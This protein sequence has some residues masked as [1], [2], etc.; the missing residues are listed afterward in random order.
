MNYFSYLFLILLIACSASSEKSEERSSSD[1]SS[2]FSGYMELTI[3]SDSFKYDN[4]TRTDSR[5]SFQDEAIAVYVKNPDGEGTI[6]QITLLSP[7]IYNSTTHTY[8]NESGRWLEE[9]AKQEYERIRQ[10]LNFKFRRIDNM[11]EENYLSLDRGTVDISYDDEQGNFKITFAGEDRPSA[12][13]KEDNDL[14]K[15]SGTLVLE[16][17][18]LMDSRN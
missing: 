12:Y 6:A 3:D 5:V 4:L 7:E 8:T 15:F 9:G 17:A 13:Y 2:G 1:S 14:V 10:N 16:G 18:Y 11:E